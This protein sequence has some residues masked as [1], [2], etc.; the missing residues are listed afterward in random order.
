MYL[1]ERSSIAKRKDD[2][3]KMRT[4]KEQDDPDEGEEHEWLISKEKTLFSRVKDV[5]PICFEFCDIET[6]ISLPF[7]LPLFYEILKQYFPTPFFYLPIPLASA[8]PAQPT[9]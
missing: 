7:P 4:R 1:K 8:P 9:Q 2:I 5:T 6:P 3:E